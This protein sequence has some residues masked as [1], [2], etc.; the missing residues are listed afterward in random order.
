MR[1]L[2][3]SIT[4]RGSVPFAAVVKKFP[5]GSVLASN[6]FDSDAAASPAGSFS[7]YVGGVLIRVQADTSKE[8]DAGTAN[9]VLGFSESE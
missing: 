7:T 2:R 4:S 1:V 3:T 9:H 6:G 5:P 8:L